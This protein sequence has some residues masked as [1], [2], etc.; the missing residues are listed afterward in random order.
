MQSA[1]AV[2]H[3]VGINYALISVLL[4]SA[5]QL[6]MK[7]AM[8]ISVFH[9][10]IDVR[11]IRTVAQIS[12]YLAALAGGLMCYAL[13]MLLWVKAL[14]TLS[15]AKAYPLLSLS[16]GL[17]Y[18]GAIMIPALNEP[19]SWLKMIGILL[20]FLGVTQIFKKPENTD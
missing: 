11:L 2:K 1:S 13:S 12:P 7:W 4:V 9:A 19:V 16:Y 10:V 18:L 17:V 15:L 5:A 3:N 20:I 8:S 6:L 14:Q